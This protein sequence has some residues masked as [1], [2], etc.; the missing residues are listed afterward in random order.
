MTA[1]AAERD[2]PTR[3]PTAERESADRE[4][5]D[6]SPTATDYSHDLYAIPAIATINNS[7]A[8]RELLTTDDWLGNAGDRVL[9]T[10][11][12]ASTN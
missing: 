11:P 7:T 8:N 1:R 12:S 10:V 9:V 2:R 4:T 3:R 5:G 6:R